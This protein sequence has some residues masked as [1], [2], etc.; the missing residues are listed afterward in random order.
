MEFEWRDQPHLL[1]GWKGLSPEE[2][3]SFIAELKRCASMWPPEKSVTDAVSLQPLSDVPWVHE[4]PGEEIGRELI[5]QGKVAAIVLAG[6]QGSR[7]QLTGPKG[8]VHSV[9][10]DPTS[11]TLFQVFA[12][13][14]MRAQKSAQRPLHLAIMTSPLNDAATRAYFSANDLFGLTQLQFFQQSMRPLLDEENRWVLERPGKL[15]KGPDGNGYLFHAL[16][17]SSILSKWE[18][19]GVEYVNVVL[20]DNP[21]ADPFEAHGIGYQHLQGSDVLLRAIKRSD[22]TEKVGIVGLHDNRVRVVEYSEMSDNNQMFDVGNTSLFSFRMDLI[23]RVLTA[24]LPWHLAYRHLGG[25]PV[26]KQEA[27]IFDL[28]MYAQNAKVLL[29]PREQIFAPLKTLLNSTR[30]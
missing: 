29:Y 22:R 15:A 13:K 24:T 19:D 3:S 1:E 12:D 30:G 4:V 17:R 26:R 7:M 25:I 21:L 9:P 11:P 14:T 6:G 18:A 2:K 16:A 5:E 28:L 8:M 10:D 20:V 27:F 23:K